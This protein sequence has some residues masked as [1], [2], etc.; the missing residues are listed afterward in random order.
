MIFSGNVGNISHQHA[1]YPSLTVLSVP[2]TILVEPSIPQV[3]RAVG[4][5]GGSVPGQ[6]GKE[7]PEHVADV[8]QK[9]LPC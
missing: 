4:S 5:G 9:S 2:P 6:Q 7:S 8:S 1:L 3:H